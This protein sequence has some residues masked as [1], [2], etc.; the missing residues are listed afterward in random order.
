MA[1]L[2]T[3]DGEAVSISLPKEK[4]EPWELRFEILAGGLVSTSSCIFG[5][6]PGLGL[7]FCLDWP[8]QCTNNSWFNVALHEAGHEREFIFHVSGQFCHTFPSLFLS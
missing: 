5:V 4:E 7:Q 2:E 8:Y 3:C 1:E 6:F